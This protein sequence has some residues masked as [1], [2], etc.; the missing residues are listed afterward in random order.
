MWRDRVLLVL[1]SLLLLASDVRAADAPRLNVL[2][3]IAD[4]LRC[5]LGCYGGPAKTPTLDAL[6]KRGVLFE[7]ACCQQAL[8]N[9]SRSS[10]LTGRRPDTLHLWHNGVHFREKNP[11]VTTLP[12]W[13]KNQGYTTRNVGKIFHNWHTKEKGDRRSWSAEEFLHYANHG[14]D[15]AKV[16]GELP[17]NTALKYGRMYGASGICECRD[18]PDNAYFDGRVADEAIRVL[19]EVKDGPFYLAVGFWK[20][21]APFNAPKKYWD[22]YDRSRLPAFDPSRP[23]GAPEVAFH[24]GRELRGVPP[25]QVDFTPEQVAEIRHGYLANIS[26]LDAQLGRILAALEKQGLAGRTVVVFHSDHGY[27][28]G[29]HQLWAKTSNFEYDARVP[30][31]VVPPGTT[32]AGKTVKTA[33]EL[34]D[35]FPTLCDLCRLKQPAGLEGTSLAATVTEGAA[36]TKKVAFT[37]HPRPAYFDRTEKG[38]PDAMGYSV[39]TAHVRYTEWR[40]WETGKVLG[41]ELYD[42][43]GDERELTNRSDRPTSPTTLAE[44]RA[45]LHR[46]F[47]PDV[48]PA[49]R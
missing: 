31:I 40:D 12:L 3:V 43:P 27:H 8:C 33:V 11:D 4:D 17:P 10:F 30:M 26:Y 22:L 14:D 32:Q 1:A 15:V 37:Q 21:H 25:R 28:L 46:Q 23:K 19:G 47:P 39:R 29:E 38:V 48:V 49:K 36:P 35:L 7:T 9:P 24:D 34:L 13:F 45:A 18:V 41:A 42:H 20:P 6:A 16:K 44:A 5:D 2:H